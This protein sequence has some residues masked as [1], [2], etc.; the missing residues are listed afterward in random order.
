[1][2]KATQYLLMYFANILLFTFYF[3]R[4]PI[5]LLYFHSFFIACVLHSVASSY[6]RRGDRNTAEGQSGGFFL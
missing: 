5:S 6:S 4:N 2:P 1:M 3:Y